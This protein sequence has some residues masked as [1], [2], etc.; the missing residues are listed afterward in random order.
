MKHTKLRRFDVKRYKNKKKQRPFLD[1][2]PLISSKN[3][4]PSGAGM[5]FYLFSA[6]DSFWTL[7][8]TVFPRILEHPTIQ[9]NSKLLRPVYRDFY[10]KYD[11]KNDFLLKCF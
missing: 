10:S 8:F 4:K 2:P 11:Q 3:N 9:G 5:K 1:H 6:E 7:K